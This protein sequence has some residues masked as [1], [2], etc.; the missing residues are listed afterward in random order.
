MLFRPPGQGWDREGIPPILEWG[1]A[2]YWGGGFLDQLIEPPDPIVPPINPP[3]LATPP[4][5]LHPI[6]GGMHWVAPPR[7]RH[8]LSDGTTDS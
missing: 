7:K 5:R 1:D 2:V 4:I 3:D 8:Q 6:N